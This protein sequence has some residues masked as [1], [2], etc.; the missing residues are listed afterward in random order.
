MMK[1]YFFFLLIA[2]MGVALVMCDSPYKHGDFVDR[3]MYTIDV[4]SDNTEMGSVTGSGEY[5][6]GQQVAIQAK[7]NEHY[8]FKTWDDNNTDN[9]RKLIVKENITYTAFF[10]LMSYQMRLAV[11]DG[12]CGSVSGGGIYQAFE[13]ATIVATPNPG[14]HFVRWSDNVKDSL[15]EIYMVRDVSLI[16]YF[17]KIQYNVTISSSDETMGTVTTTS[18][19]ENENL[20]TLEATPNQGYEFVDWSDGN[21]EN[22]RYLTLTQDTTLIANFRGQTHS[23]VVSVNNRNMGSV[24]GGGT[25]TTPE[26]VRLVATPNSGYVFVRW[27]DGNTDNPR[28]FVAMES[29][30]LTAYFDA[31]KYNVSVSANDPLLGTVTGGGTYGSN[32]EVT[33]TATPNAGCTFEGWDD[34]NTDNPRTVT[35]TADAT[36]VANFS[37]SS[38]TVSVAANDNNMG[39]VTGSGT[40]QSG[41]TATIEAIP[42]SPYSFVKWNDGSTENPRNI[43]VTE[44]VSYV[45]EFATTY[46]VVTVASANES[47]G[48]ATG[49][50][51]FSANT[52]TTITATANEGY[53]FVKWSDENTDNPRTI[54]VTQN[55]TYTA[56]FR[57]LNASSG[58]THENHDYVDLGLPSGT[59]WATCNVGANSPEEIGS[60][61]AWGEIAPKADYTWATYTHTVNGGSKSLTKYNPDAGYGTVDNKAVLELSDDAA[62]QNWGGNWRMPT[63]DEMAELMSNCTVTWITQNGVSGKQFIGPN[64]NTIFVP[65]TGY[66]NGTSLY[67]TSDGYYWTSK[68]SSDYPNEAYELFVNAS[69]AYFSDSYRSRGKAIRPVVSNLSYETKYTLT[70]FSNDDMMGSVTGSGS[71]PYGSTITLTAYANAGYEFIS[72]SDGNTD[73]PRTITVYQDETLTANFDV[74]GYTLIVNSNDESMGSVTGSGRYTPNSVVTI[75]ATPNSGYEFVEWNDGNTEAT[76][77]ITLT[78]NTTYTAT[79]RAV[80][81]TITVT[82]NNSSMGTVSGGGSYVANATAILTAEPAV[83]YAFVY[84]SDWNTDNPRE[85]YVTGDATYEAIFE[86]VYYTLSLSVNDASMG[87][88][89]GAG[90]YPAQ[91]AQTIQATPYADYK[92]VS[93]SDGN[94]DNPRTVTMTANIDLQANFES[95]KGVHNSHEY[96]DLGLPSGTLWATCN[97]GS[98]DPLTAGN[99]YAW[100]EV[101]P[102]ENYEWTTYKHCAGTNTTLTKYNSDSMYGSVDNKTTLDLEDDAAYVNWGGGWRVPTS[103]QLKELRE[104][105]NWTWVS[106]QGYYQVVG[107]NGSSLLI[108]GNG[109]KSGS[110]VSDGGDVCLWASSVWLDSSSYNTYASYLFQDYYYQSSWSITSNLRYYGLQ[111]RPVYVPE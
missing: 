29:L 5:M 10:D 54:V 101:D 72:W 97:I 65:A 96:I 4:R 107:P 89:S 88:V 8:L 105:C 58:G 77:T 26:V 16:A 108:K 40:Y 37:A 81:Y 22:P 6:S 100:G 92:F 57:S 36:Y 83:G 44:N 111:I 41:T 94:T 87:S 15:R 34:G 14:S 51:T 20:L 103:Q 68:I 56:Q 19:P 106:A 47:M 84:W 64:G 74:E 82:T 80:S 30:V 90:S 49:G 52:T 1:R 78:E 98:N 76:R 31:S 45:A 99:Y 67:S 42:Y 102:K 75:T 13:T 12:N 33:L 35:V 43:L 95:V 66:Y 48:I 46:Y 85:V 63:Y 27:S 25:Y 110:Y 2:L 91:S 21:T 71:Y 3:R 55:A 62:Y 69:S 9:P 104:Q 18:A 11:N 32:E 38:Y 93:W 86:A 28:E 60:Y 109:Y 59:L 24:T 50:G 73:N 53:E 61:Y 17:D 39:Y 7:P 70:G 23:I 79:F